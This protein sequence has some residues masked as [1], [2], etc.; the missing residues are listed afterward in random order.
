V[1]PLI[2][3]VEEPIEAAPTRVCSAC[4]ETKPFDVK[5]WYADRSKGKGLKPRG[6]RCKSCYR[7]GIKS[8][9][10]MEDISTRQAGLKRAGVKAGKVDP[11]A[12]RDAMAGGVG[13]LN[14]YAGDLLAIVMAYALDPTSPEHQWALKL[15]TE[16][17]M[18]AKMFAELGLNAAGLLKGGKEQTR[19]V[20]I[21]VNE[22]GAKPDGMGTGQERSGDGSDE[23]VRGDDGDAGAGSAAAVHPVDADRAGVGPGAGV[24]AQTGDP[25]AAGRRD[26]QG[27]PEA[28]RPVDFDSLL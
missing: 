19:S 16:R 5:N 26:A 7:S 15:M 4:G 20:T 23:G 27:L 3:V 13:A 1:K 6:T 21:T 18:P 12:L 25:D 24:P 9:K 17:V 8:A 28:P 11:R 10:Q 22:L 14:E 2:E